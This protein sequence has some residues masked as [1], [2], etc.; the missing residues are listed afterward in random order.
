MPAKLKRLNIDYNKMDAY[1]S[2]S[3]RLN[4]YVRSMAMEINARAAAHFILFNIKT[5]E[6]RVSE[7]TPPKYAASFVVRKIDRARRVAY[8]ARNN[9]RAA[10]WVEYGAHAGGVTLVLKYSPYR[11]ALAGMAVK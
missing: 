1:L 11:V 10:A 5:N 8:E 4:H 3:P 9:D 6:G 2:E 7:T